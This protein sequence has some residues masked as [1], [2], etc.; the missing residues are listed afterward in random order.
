M[1]HLVAVEV[2]VPNNKQEWELNNSNM[3]S[4]MWT[5][6]NALLARVT[7]CRK[8]KKAINLIFFFKTPSIRLLTMKGGGG[9]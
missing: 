9:G 2:D 5:S 4:I 3:A 6:K 8:F 7:K 1:L